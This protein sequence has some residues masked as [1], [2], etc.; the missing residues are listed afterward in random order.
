M[1]REIRPARQL[2][3][4][5][6]LWGAMSTSAMMVITFMTLLIPAAAGVF[7]YGSQALMVI[8][9][10]LA[11]CILTDLACRKLRGQPLRPDGSTLVTGM[12]LALVLPPMLPLWMV[13]TGAV[14][15]IAIVK[16]AFGGLGQNIF[17]PAMGARAF[18]LASFAAPMSR[19]IEPLG[20][21]T[22]AVTS[23]TPLDSA[24]VTELTKVELYQALLMGDVPG[25]IGGGALFVIIGG[26]LLLATGII[27]FKTPLAYL[28]AVALAALA[29]GQDPVFHLLAGG[30]M[31]AAFYF[32]TDPVTTP[33][34]WPGKLLFAAG[35]G[36]LTVLIR[37]LGNAPDGI[38]YAV[39]LMNCVTPLIDRYIKPEAMGVVRNKDNDAL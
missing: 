1:N 24:F 29:F 35:A 10:C 36:V 26:I 7:N 16:E 39:L 6:H 28:G 17:N 23:A 13:F 34:Y 4:A 18:L 5:P 8:V 3:P 31:F 32:V 22:D 19:W 15:A 9:A 20:F 25:V 30:S 33:V 38:A 37:E 14:F 12:L 11:G 2:S 21:G 27:D